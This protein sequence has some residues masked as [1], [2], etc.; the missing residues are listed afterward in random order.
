MSWHFLSVT[1]RG[2][3]S[4]VFTRTGS[5]FTLFCVEVFHV[6]LLFLLDTGLFG[7]SCTYPNPLDGR[8]DDW[9]RE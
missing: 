3:L 4:Y 9:A 1:Q 8:P 6:K 2:I 7:P 5:E